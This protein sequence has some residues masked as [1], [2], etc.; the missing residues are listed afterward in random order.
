VTG[1]LILIAS[2][3]G[4]VLYGW[5]LFFAKWSTLLLQLTGFIGVAVVLGMLAWIGYTLTT[6][7]PPKLVEQTEGE[8]EGELMEFEDET[9][10]Q[11][12]EEEGQID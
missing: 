9:K 6:T 12:G 3:I 5:I 2:V 10:E 7:P 11:S 1:A 4:I 8:F